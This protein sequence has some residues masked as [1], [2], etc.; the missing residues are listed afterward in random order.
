MSCPAPGDLIRVIVGTPKC[1]YGILIA[2][3]QNKVKL[4]DAILLEPAWF[5]LTEYGILQSDTT[6]FLVIDHNYLQ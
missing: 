3:T 5:V 2:P 6:D 1:V 4:D